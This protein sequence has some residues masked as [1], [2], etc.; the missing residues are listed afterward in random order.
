MK[1]IKLLSSLTVF[2]VIIGFNMINANSNSVT[3]LESLDNLKLLNASAAEAG[4]RA[5][6][7]RACI[8]NTGQIV[9]NGYGIPFV[10]W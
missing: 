1:K 9:M 4:C 10:N 3:T 8:I 7:D 5:V 6:N 2:A